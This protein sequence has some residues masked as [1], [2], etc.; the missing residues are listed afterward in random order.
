MMMPTRKQDIAITTL[1][2][3]DNTMTSPP[4]HERA[5]PLFPA[6]GIA[7]DERRAHERHRRH[8]ISSPSTPIIAISRKAIFTADDTLTRH[9]FLTSFCRDLF[10]QAAH[11]KAQFPLKPAFGAMIDGQL[12]AYCIITALIPLTFGRYLCERQYHAIL[13]R[14][15]TH[16]DAASR[17]YFIYFQAAYQRAP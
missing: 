15:D 12:L 9:Y 16:A 11:L 7:R 2:H 8:L 13:L 4:R 14:D 6:P 5:M 10:R 3:A 1:M 17:R